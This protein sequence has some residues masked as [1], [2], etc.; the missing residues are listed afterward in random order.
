MTST[1]LRQIK[2]GRAPD[3]VMRLGKMDIYHGATVYFFSQTRG[4][5][6]SVVF[7]NRSLR[8]VS[9]NVRDIFD[10]NE[11]DTPPKKVEETI[12]TRRL[13]LKSRNGYILV[14]LRLPKNLNR[15]AILNFCEYFRSVT[16]PAQNKETNPKG[17]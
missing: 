15:V 17:S 4:Y 16:L 7:S 5:L 13:L 3:F 14:T 11:T 9:K 1:S 10:A 8:I 12:A 2:I 6:H